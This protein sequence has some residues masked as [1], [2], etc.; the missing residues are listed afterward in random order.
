[1]SGG[2]FDYIQFRIEGIAEEIIAIV[3]EN[4]NTDKN[5]W[6]DDVGY[7]YPVEVVKRFEKAAHTIRRAGAMIHCIDWLLSGDDGEESFLSR[8]DEDVC[9]NP[10]QRESK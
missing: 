8:W 2:H 5:D 7:H 10:K 6:G 1:M 3:D 9:H 4:D